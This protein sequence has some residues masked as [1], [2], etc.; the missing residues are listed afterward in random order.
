MRAGEI[1]GE[2]DWR[3]RGWGRLRAA[4]MGAGGMRPAAEGERSQGSSS[5]GAAGSILIH[6]GGTGRKNV[7][8]WRRR[9]RLGEKTKKKRRVEGEPGGTREGAVRLG[10]GIAI[11]YPGYRIYLLYIYIY[12]MLYIYIA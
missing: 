11:P 7:G 2:R 5:E 12:I 9:I 3:R 10:Y 4:E 6:G 1:K 8:E